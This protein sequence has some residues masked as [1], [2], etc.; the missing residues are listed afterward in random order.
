MYRSMTT[1]AIVIRRQR[2]GEYHKNLTLLTSDLGLI[3]ATAYGAYKMRAGCA[4]EA[5]RSRWPARTL[6]H[7]PVRK[8]Y[9]VTD[10]EI[11]QTF[12]GLTADL[13]RLAAASLWAEVAIRSYAAG[14]VSDLLFRLFLD[15]LRALEFAGER[16]RAVRHVAVPVA[17]PDAR[18]IPAGHLGLRVLRRRL[19]R[20]VSG[21]VR[22]PFQLARV[23]QLRRRLREFAFPRA[24]GATWRP[25]ALL[26]LNRPRRCASKA[27]P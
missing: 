12:E 23:R 22:S 6:Y 11:L 5:S 15:C 8:S 1:Q 13:S 9:K 20:V 25:A 14:E 4:W 7:N 18:R 24:R 16:E 19:W 17:F 27:L 21:L 3:Y 10:L 2:Q 26:P